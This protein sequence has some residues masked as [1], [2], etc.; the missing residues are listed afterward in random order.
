MGCVY[1]AAN[2]EAAQTIKTAIHH[3]ETQSRRANT[4]P[5]LA[6]SFGLGNLD[7]EAAFTYSTALGNVLEMDDLARTA[8]LHAGPVIIPA[9]LYSALQCGSNYHQLLNAIVR[10]YEAAIRLGN[11]LDAYHYQRWHP[12]S[13]AGVAGAAVAAAAI[14]QLNTTQ[15]LT[16]LCNAL[17]VSGGLWHTRHGNSMTKQWHS[18]HTA[19][20]GVSAVHSALYGF[21][22][23]EQIIE[24]EQGWHQVLADSPSP[25]NIVNTDDW[26]IRQTS[27]KPWPACRHCH[28]AIDAAL[29]INAELKNKAELKISDR[30]TKSQIKTIEAVSV[31]TYND[32][33]IFCDRVSPTT[34]AEARFSLQHSIAV[35][36]I[37]GTV[38]PADFEIDTI[39]DVELQTLRSKT[40]VTSCPQMTQ[41]YPAHFGSTVTLTLN[42]GET[43]KETIT[44]AM[45]DPEWPLSEQQIRN[46][47]DMLCD[48][49]IGDHSKTQ[50][51]ADS[52]L[53]APEHTEVAAL[54]K[55]AP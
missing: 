16:A 53:D 26:A 32:A 51:L 55:S 22:A 31:D 13:T 30:L 12:T 9:A 43:L 17:S 19:R 4:A 11:S 49:G 41:N 40:T 38:L 5:T 28:A 39:R 45:G 52:V 8:I 47:F 18:V 25:E 29:K 7:F 3:A 42:N 35:A 6:P 33:Q 54:V 2:E 27:F 48:W 50:H 14:Y 34:A 1:G 24:G 46:K 21:T 37:K 23:A 15:Q 44:D 36:L 20:T 10:G